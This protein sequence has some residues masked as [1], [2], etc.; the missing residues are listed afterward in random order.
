MKRTVLLVSLLLLSLSPVLGQKW[1][2]STDLPYW[3][4]GVANLD[5]EIALGRHFTLDLAGGY[6][7]YKVFDKLDL[8]ESW[9]VQ[10]ELRWWHCERF[11]GHYFGLHGHYADYNAAIKSSRYDGW[12][13]GGGLSYGYQWI[14]GNRWNFQFEIGAGYAYKDYTKHNADG[15]SVDKTKNYFGPTKFNLSFVYFIL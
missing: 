9:G 4:V 6:A 8:K 13:A 5:T 3:G 15:T 2:I 14:L 12:L 1:A 10:P 7:A 11:N